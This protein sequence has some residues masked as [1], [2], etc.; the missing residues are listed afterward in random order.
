MHDN[1][2]LGFSFRHRAINLFL[3][4]YC[5]EWLRNSEHSRH[6]LLI[7]E[8]LDR[9]DYLV[10]QQLRQREAK[11]ANV[12]PHLQKE[13]FHQLLTGKLDL[14]LD[15]LSQLFKMVQRYSTTGGW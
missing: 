2:F 1:P 13:T 3:R 9:Q 4:I 12:T 7:E 8:L 10:Q 14:Q 5:Q 15:P 11:L 6:Q